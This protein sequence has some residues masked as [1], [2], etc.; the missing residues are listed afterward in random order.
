MS[1]RLI[2]G[3]K[4]SAQ[5]LSE[6][7]L[8]ISD[9][10]VKTGLPPGLSLISVGDDPASNIYVR[11]KERTAA[12]VGIFAKAHR[13]PFKSTAMEVK[14]L[15]ENLNSD[16]R[17]HGIVVQLPLPEHIDVGTVLR[18]IDP[19]KD[20]DGLHPFNVGLLASGHPRFIPATPGGIR[21]ML[22]RTNNMPSGKHVV[23]VGRSNIVGRP[24]SQLLSAR[25]EG[26]NAT[27]TLCHSHTLELSS[28]CRL[29]DIIIVA[30]GV[31]NF[32]TGDMVSDGVVAIDVGINRVNTPVSRRGYK[33]VGDI[34][35][36]TVSKKAS[37]I[38]KVPGGVGPMT[39]A[40]LLSN[41]LE[42]AR[43]SYQGV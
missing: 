9:I 18:S 33:L 2:D 5:T 12:S 15:I 23:I 21:Q 29:A 34:D 38:S 7:A 35:F 32:L 26:G 31:P 25:I 10:K 36:S 8:G 37:A 30:V 11:T 13:L 19:F 27:V 1:Y 41:T 43:M 22:L 24:L 3:R 17:C 39:V 16:P 6:L 40:M 28:I 14:T 20:V 4:L 42:A